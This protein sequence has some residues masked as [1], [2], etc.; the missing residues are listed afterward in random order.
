MTSQFIVIW[1]CASESTLLQLALQGDFHALQV[2]NP[3]G[4]EVAS[5]WLELKNV[6]YVFSWGENLKKEFRK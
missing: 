1:A 4:R 6:K 3:D 2:V 5:Y